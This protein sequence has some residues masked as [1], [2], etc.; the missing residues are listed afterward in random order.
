MDGKTG[1]KKLKWSQCQNEVVKCKK[2]EKIGLPMKKDV[3]S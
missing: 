1:L 2:I 3:K